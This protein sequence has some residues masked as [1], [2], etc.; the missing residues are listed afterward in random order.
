MISVLYDVTRI[1]VVTYLYN[2]II[3]VNLKW[4]SGLWQMP[5]YPETTLALG[6]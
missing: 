2:T 6:P 5:E 3:M 1:K 4:C